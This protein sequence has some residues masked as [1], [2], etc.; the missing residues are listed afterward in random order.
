M[1]FGERRR[2]GNINK[3]WGYY[4]NRE[5]LLP[6]GF[7]E[8]DFIPYQIVNLLRSLAKGEVYPFVLSFI[9]NTVKT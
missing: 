8:V 9:L 3:S 7:D 6:L 1:D 4:I 5:H 2:V